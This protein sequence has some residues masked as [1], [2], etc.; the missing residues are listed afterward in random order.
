MI[1]INTA[2]YYIES[3]FFFFLS[4]TDEPKFTFFFFY[5]TTYNIK[6]P[7]YILGIKSL[8]CF[9]VVWN[10]QSYFLYFLKRRI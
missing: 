5:N 10:W 1:V 2:N 7:I 6:N 8:K 3:N 4:M 9:Y